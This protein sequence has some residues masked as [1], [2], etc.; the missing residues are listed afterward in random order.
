VTDTPLREDLL[1]GAEEIAEFIGRDV[2]ATYYLL[3]QKLLPAIK[4]G[5]VWVTTKSRLRRH[6]NGELPPPTPLAAPEPS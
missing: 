4:E 5:D 2:R 1:R 6:Y 3:Q